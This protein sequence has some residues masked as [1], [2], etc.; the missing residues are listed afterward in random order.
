MSVSPLA[1]KDERLAINST[2]TFPG[3]VATKEVDFTFAPLGLPGV[4]TRKWNS[5]RAFADKLVLP[6]FD[7]CVPASGSPFGG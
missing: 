6:S 2:V 1:R 7:F 5:L 4:A 3:Q